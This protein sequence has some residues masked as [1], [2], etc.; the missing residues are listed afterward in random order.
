MCECDVI[1]FAFERMCFY[2]ME[3]IIVVSLMTR[4][5]N[6]WISSFIKLLV[7]AVITV[8]HSWKFLNFHYICNRNLLSEK[9]LPVKKYKGNSKIAFILEFCAY[10]LKWLLFYDLKIWWL[11]KIKMFKIKSNLTRKKITNILTK[12]LMFWAF[13]SWKI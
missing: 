2:L 10:W 12:F 13:C 1:N 4:A 9:L 11:V 6:L 3:W 5:K 8:S 7:L